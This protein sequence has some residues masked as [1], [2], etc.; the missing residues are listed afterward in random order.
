M[1]IL[2]AEQ[3]RQADQFTIRNEPIPSIALMERASLA[4]TNWFVTHFSPI[5]VVHV[6]CGTGNNGGDG[7]VVARLLLERT[8]KVQVYVVGN[9]E[10]GSKDFTTNLNKSSG[11]SHVKDVEDL[12]KP[13]PEDVIIDALFGSGLSRPVA[14]LYQEIITHL[15]LLPSIKV[16]VDIPSGLFADQSSQG[17]IFTAD[18]TVSFQQPKLAFFFPQ[19]AP[20]VGEWYTIP[21]GLDQSF[22]EEQPTSH[23][24][25]SRSYIQ[26][27]IKSRKKY[28]HKGTY[29]K[30]LIMAGSYGKVGA[31]VLAAR[32]A[33]R[34]GVGLLTVY[35]PACGYT[36]I[37]TAVPEA[38]VI[39]DNQDNEL[40][41]IP[42]FDNYE[43]IGIGPGIGK[44][45]YALESIKK[46]LEVAQLPLVIDADGLNLISEN[47]ELLQMV[48]E[49]SILTPHPT[50]FRRLAGDWKDDFERLG[51][52]KAFSQEYN[53]ILLV[54]GAHS[55]LTTPAGD[56]YFNVTGNPGMAT[57]GSG[58]VLTGIITALLAQGYAPEDA[59]IIGMF[60]HGMAGDIACEERGQ[61]GLIASDIVANISA[62]FK[63]NHR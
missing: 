57:A 31:A 35:T 51:K 6:I 11:F 19:N 26:D 22:I 29:G 44:S 2:S 8:Y 41:D 50:E 45:R 21:I 38:M 49:H 59:G 23:F 20:Y 3:I 53:V 46:T 39:A 36:I 16:A 34:S 48:P 40:S 55:T 7:L 43:A 60:I 17:T 54:K 61:T 42:S 12:P 27:K 1:K 28:D 33:L 47:R 56:V 9:I 58:D 30:A 52:Q 15:N 37:Q 14:G 62:A 24:A 13:G 32:A 5:H 63:K 18:H 25:L 10:A 4:F